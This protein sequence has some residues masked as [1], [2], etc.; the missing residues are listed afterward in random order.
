M[1]KISEVYDSAAIAVYQ[2]NEKS[3][4][5]PP[6]GEAFF[7][8]ERKASIDIKEIKTASG[9]PVSLAPSNFDAKSTIRT[10]KGFK[11]NER[12]MAFFRES[13]VVSERDRIELAKLS[14]CTSPFVKDVVKRMY[15]D[16]KTLV[17]GAD[18]VPER[19]R[20]QLLFPESGGPKIYFSSDGVVYSYDYDPDGSWNTNNR[21]DLSGVYQ[22][23]NTTTAK[24]LTDIQ[25]IIENAVE[26]I[27]YLVMSQAELNLFMACEQVKQAVLAQNL[28]A[29]VFMTATVAKQLVAT[30]FPGVELLVYKKKYKDEAGAPLAFVPDG[31]VA[32]IPEGTLGSTFFGM[33]PEELAQLEAKDV[34]ITILPSGV[35]VAVQTSYDTT[36]QTTTT[37]AETVLPS[38]ERMDSVYLLATGT[39]EDAGGSLD[40]LTVALAAGTATDST[41]ATVTETLGSGNS[42]KI[43][44]FAS[45]AA[46]LPNYEQNLQT[47]TVYTEG[48]DILTGVA[49]GKELVIVEVNSNY[50]AVAAA[51]VTIGTAN[52]KS[53]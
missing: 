12:E 17:D 18:V 23:A 22:W 7:P 11:I 33:T 14:D 43:K 19:M 42:Y 39:V 27:K 1:I 2:K 20:M 9:L 8:N 31:Y 51:M 4:E 48:A 41:K 28:T 13:M 45:G 15:D 29:N 49:D 24:P 50:L 25:K 47:W 44:I 5:I 21:T 10:R 6:L 32:F 37:V 38:Y 35:A 46:V 36:M 40:A 26:S 30:M 34:D 52:I 53:A 16:V 3:N